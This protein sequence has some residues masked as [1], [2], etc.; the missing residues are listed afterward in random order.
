MPRRKSKTKALKKLHYWTEYHGDKRTYRSRGYNMQDER[1]AKLFNRLVTRRKDML[2]KRNGG[3]LY[4]S[5]D[6][7]SD[8]PAGKTFHYGKVYSR[9]ARSNVSRLFT[10]NAPLATSKSRTRSNRSS[11]N[12]RSKSDTEE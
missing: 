12:K 11:R 7:I 3:R 10:H 2:A 5:D 8:A 1:D 4:D 6:P 9:S